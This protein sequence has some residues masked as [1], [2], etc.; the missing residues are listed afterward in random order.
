MNQNQDQN[1]VSHPPH[2]PLVPFSYHSHPV[3]TIK[4]PDKSIWFVAKDV[5]EV[6]DIVNHRHAIRSLEDDEKGVAKSDT[7]GGDQS[8]AIISESGLYALIFRSNKPEAKTFRKWVTAEVLPAIRQNGAYATVHVKKPH[9]RPAP[10]L[11][12][13]VPEAIAFGA[14]CALQLMDRLVKSN[15][16]INFIHKMARYRAM[17]LTQRETATLMNISRDVLRAF[18]ALAKA[19]GFFEPKKSRP[20]PQIT[21]ISSHSSCVRESQGEGVH[22]E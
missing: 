4:K 7:L 8:V 2:N 19:C 12:Q 6:L 17:G 11:P 18:E 16:D 21:I 5:C 10:A 15:R 22:H 13:T 1:H 20:K 9:H 14:S 3:R